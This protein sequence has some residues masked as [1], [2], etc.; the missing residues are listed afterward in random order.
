MRGFGTGMLLAFVAV[1]AAAQEWTGWRGANRDAKVTFAVPSA[2][3]KALEK[4]WSVEVGTGH[5][6]PALLDGK[7]YVH[8]RQGDDE[9][10]L[11]LDAATGETIW[12]D[13]YPVSYTMD[14]TATEHGKGP[15]SS[16]AVSDG[17]MVTF[18]ITGVMTCYDTKSGEKVWRRDFLEEFK[19][20]CPQ[21]G[22]AMSPLVQ[23]GVVYAHIGGDKKGAIVALD[24]ATGKAKWRWDGDGPGYSSPIIRTVG[25]RR[26]LITQTQFFAVGLAPEDGSVLWQLDYKTNYDQNSVSPVVFGNTVVMSGFQLGTTA[27]DVTGDEAKLVWDTSKV[28]MYMSTPI[29]KGDLVYGFSQKRRGQFF[30]LDAKTGDVVWR[31]DGRQG[32]NA[33]LVDAGEVFLAVTTESEL[34]AFKATDEDYEELA[35]YK[36]AETPTWAHPVVAGKRVFI[37]DENHLTE[38]KLP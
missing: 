4:G 8:A 24:L 20:T 3:P 2:W 23:D 35:R 33:A 30:C 14:P 16:V 10:A 26:Q 36:V 15:K 21:Y 1:S 19:A 12:R 7:L 31:G 9:V 34:V 22:V 13:A 37:K 11:C 27:H 5:A 28:S 38:W 17:K 32:E 29:V 25:G 18:G 6:T